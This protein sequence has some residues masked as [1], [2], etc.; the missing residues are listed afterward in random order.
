MSMLLF[1]SAQFK[2]KMASD[3]LCPCFFILSSASAVASRV[4]VLLSVMVDGYRGS[5]RRYRALE[6]FWLLF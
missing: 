2:T 1:A 6:M 3:M 4:S 5:T